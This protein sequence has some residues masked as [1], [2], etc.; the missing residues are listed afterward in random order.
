[1]ISISSL[2]KAFFQFLFFISLVQL[3]I[4]GTKILMLLMHSLERKKC[5]EPCFSAIKLSM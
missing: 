4:I 2:I 5:I 1:M 3:N